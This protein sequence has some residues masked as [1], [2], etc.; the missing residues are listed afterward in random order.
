M[1]P[2]FQ[3]C[4]SCIRE[5]VINFRFLPCRTYMTNT[6]CPVCSPNACEKN[7]SWYLDGTRTHDL[8]LSSADVL[9]T[10]PPNLPVATGWFE[11]IEQWVLRTIFQRWFGFC[12]REFVIH[13]RF[14]PDLTYIT[15]NAQCVHPMLVKKK[16]KLL[17]TTSCFLVQTS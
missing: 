9:T 1:I 4:Y 6:E 16:R 8:L 11:Y 5:I 12:V 3:R 2:Y 7:A 10:R 15:L 17:L 13:F 14:L